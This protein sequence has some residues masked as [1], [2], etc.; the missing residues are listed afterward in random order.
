MSE[1]ET[2]WLAY[3]ETAGYVQRTSSK[4]RAVR[5]VKDGTL[6][7]R[8]QLLLVFLDAA[9]T[10]GLTW[11]QLAD[12]T[13][14]HHGQVSGALSN[15][16]GAGMVF[17]LRTQR[18]KCHPYVHSKYSN[19]FS[20][21]ERHDEPARTRSGTRLAL[22]SELL[23]VCRTGDAVAIATTVKKVDALLNGFADGI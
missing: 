11:K 14:L 7:K 9:G 19:K 2:I 21:A 5:E 10:D 15:L 12:I 22:L 4:E 23:E 20:N 1:Q 3:G 8:Q 13:A 17:M 6:S 16:H 18:N